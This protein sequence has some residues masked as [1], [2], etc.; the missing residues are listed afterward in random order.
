MLFYLN[1]QFKKRLLNLYS[2]GVSDE[3]IEF[4]ELRNSF[5][6]LL[7]RLAPTKGFQVEI[8]EILAAKVQILAEET[9]Q[10][11]PTQMKDFAAAIIFSSFLEAFQEHFLELINTVNFRRVTEEVVKRCALKRLTPCLFICRKIFSAA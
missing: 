10:I 11:L 2:S 3:L 8:K 4:Q 7:E 5:I 6:Q 9:N 1:L